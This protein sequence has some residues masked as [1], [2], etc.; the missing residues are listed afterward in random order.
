MTL[1][2]LKTFFRNLGVTAKEVSRIRERMK[3]S[4]IDWLVQDS[5]LEIDTLNCLA[6]TFEALFDELESEFRSVRIDELDTRFIRLFRI[7]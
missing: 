7:K 1:E 3:T 2:G 4:F 5:K 6:K